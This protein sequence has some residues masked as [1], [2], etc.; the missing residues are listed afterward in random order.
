LNSLFRRPVDNQRR[1][2]TW[3]DYYFLPK[4]I[5]QNIAAEKFIEWEEVYAGNFYGTLKS[6]IDRI[7]NNGKHVIFDIE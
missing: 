7:W 3:Q 1:R 6:E 4:K 2:G 5:S